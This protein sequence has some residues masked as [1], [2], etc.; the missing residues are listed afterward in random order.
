MLTH[1][2]ELGAKGI[3][4][5]R[6]EDGSENI[7][8]KMWLALLYKISFLISCY[9]TKGLLFTEVPGS[10]NL[11]DLMPDDLRWG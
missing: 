9:N 6:N 11:Q 2:K 5:K 4:G 8:F 3:F 7:L 10:P 1:Y